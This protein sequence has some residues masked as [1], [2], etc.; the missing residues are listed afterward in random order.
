MKPEDI[1]Q[2]R[3]GSHLIKLEKAKQAIVAEDLAQAQSLLQ[4]VLSKN[5]KDPDAL[6]LMGLL[7]LKTGKTQAAIA[8]IE[9][10]IALRPSNSGF[11]G[12]CGEAYRR[13]GDLE[14]ALKAVQRALEIDPQNVQAW[15]TCGSVLRE[16]GQFDEAIA[17]YKK[18]IGIESKDAAAHYNLGLALLAK[19]N[20]REGWSEYE[21]RWQD[22][23]RAQRRT[24]DAP[25]WS[26]QNLSQRTLFVYQEQ[27]LGDTIQFVRYLPLLASQG[28]HIILE[29]APTF[30]RLFQCLDNIQLI[31]PDS[32]MPAFDYHIPLLS[33]PLVLGTEEST[34]PWGKPY[35]SPAPETE[36]KWRERLSIHEDG[37][38]VGICWAGNANHV[39][40][41]NR[42][43][44]LS[45]FS[46]LAKMKGA[47]FYSLQK[48]DAA[49]QAQHP[50]PG[51]K[52]LD[53]TTELHDLAETAGLIANL[54]LIV[55]VD[56]AVAHLAG[57]LG[58]PVW[59]LTP[60]DPDWRWLLNRT[61]SPWYP[62][63]K[64]FRQV[65]KRNWHDV[66][67]ALGEAA[68]K[69]QPIRNIDAK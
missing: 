12:N 7:G 1:R 64:L 59:M 56:T 6:H 57:A 58:R 3:L 13:S 20:F 27:G 43:C 2:S 33:I 18:A 23:Q 4:S 54:D 9:K 46:I 42:S 65:R 16:A 38:R 35:L 26:G 36:N 48:G 8:L 37:V 67:E 40:D 28:A 19:G 61:D 53:F 30:R 29:C 21:Y 31:L 49:N 45:A 44:R 41:R 14:R 5:E 50:I 22:I 24:Y 11:H 68:E 15:C 10:A 69:F 62:T 32:A 60:F 66:F 52:I 34:I 63:M 17:A 39:N 55:T 25:R 51:M 47:R